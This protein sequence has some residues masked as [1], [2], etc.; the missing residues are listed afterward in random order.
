MEIRLAFINNC[1][2]NLETVKA[3]SSEMNSILQMERKYLALCI[4]L[5]VAALK[6]NIKMMEQAKIEII[7]QMQKEI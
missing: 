2:M 7:S 5:M 1:N 4:I 6:R 3:M